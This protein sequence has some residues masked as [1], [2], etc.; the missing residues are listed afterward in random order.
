MCIQA[1]TDE[2]LRLLEFL[3]IWHMKA[4]RLLALC[5]GCR[6]P[7]GDTLIL[8][9]FRWWVNLRATLWLEGLSQRKIPMIP[10]GIEPATFWLVAQCLNHLRHCVPQACDVPFLIVLPRCPKTATECWHL[11]GM[12][13]WHIRLL[14][15]SYKSL[16]PCTV[17]ILVMCCIKCLLENWNVC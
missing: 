11:S 17:K 7:L 3:D 4:A 10:S 6:Y 16:F 13:H 9:S 8:I 2:R 15:S 12:F 14:C 1:W 5:A